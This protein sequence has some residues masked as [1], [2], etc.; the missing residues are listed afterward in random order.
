ME[1]VREKVNGNEIK[2]KYRRAVILDFNVDGN[3]LDLM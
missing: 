1:F 2:E 3:I